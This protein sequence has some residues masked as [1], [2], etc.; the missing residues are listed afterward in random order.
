MLNAKQSHGAILFGG[1]LSFDKWKE[2][3]DHYVKYTTQNRGAQVTHALG[4]K[5]FLRG[6]LT[7]R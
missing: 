3:G 1:K 4:A 5:Y 2:E 7:E 6:T